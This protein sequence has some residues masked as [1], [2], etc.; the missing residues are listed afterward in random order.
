MTRLTF[1][2]NYHIF[3]FRANKSMHTL[4]VTNAHLQQ[5]AV[6]SYI[7]QQ[8]AAS[9]VMGSTT[10]Y[11]F[12][13]MALA[14]HLSKENMETRLREMCQYLIGPVFKSSKSDWD[15]KIVG[16]DKHDMLREVLTILATN[17]RLQRIYSEFKEQLDLLSTS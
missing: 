3:W 14:Q 7:D 12:W 9:F 13:F 2:S 16:N 5:S 1:T 17:L 15:S 8:L 6:L 10:E 11:H 4:F